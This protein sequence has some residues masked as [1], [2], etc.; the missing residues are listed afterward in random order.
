VSFPIFVKDARLTAP[1]INGSRT[2]C[3]ATQISFATPIN[4]N[5]RS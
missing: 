2:V 4:P 5:I 3:P 1:S